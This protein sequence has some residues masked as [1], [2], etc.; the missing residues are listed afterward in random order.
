MFVRDWGVAA[1]RGTLLYI[2]GLGESGLCF[3]HLFAHP[4]LAEWRQLVPDMP[5][6][7]RS[8]W[9]A[10]PLSL[11]AQA[12]HLA[13]WLRECPA[14]RDAAP[15]VVVGHSLG[16]VLGLLFCERHPDLVAAFVDVDG[17]KSAADC[18][19]SSRAATFSKEDFLSGGFDRLRETVFRQGKTDAAHRGYYVSLRLA[20]P[21]TYHLHSHE[22][23]ALSETEDLAP[24]LQALPMP[25]YYIAGVPNGV[26]ARSQALL[27]EAEVDWIRIEPS[28]HWPFIDQPDRFVKALN[29]FLQR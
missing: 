23:L 14:V 21:R 10:V 26:S 3:E 12:D 19:F 17:N 11:A 13:Q 15:V 9:P 22:L 16:G 29:A 18:V 6:Y 27:T 2:H 1:P 28:G 20:D 7:G 8:P 4:G 24:R 5:G 25:T